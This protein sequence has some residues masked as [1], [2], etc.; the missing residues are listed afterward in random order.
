MKLLITLIGIVFIV[1]GIPYVAFPEA[2]Q[3]WLRQLLEM[4][5]AQLRAMGLVAMAFGLLICY[6]VQKTSWFN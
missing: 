2:M 3:K 6:V 1:E 5:P 4:R